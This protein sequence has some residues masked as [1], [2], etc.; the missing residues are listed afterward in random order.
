VYPTYAR[1]EDHNCAP[2]AV[3]PIG[4]VGIRNTNANA[5][6]IGTYDH[7]SV[8]VFLSWTTY[9]SAISLSSRRN[10]TREIT[11][12]RCRMLGSCPSWRASL[13][14]LSAPLPRQSNT[15][16][17]KVCDGSQ[18]SRLSM[19]CSEFMEAHSPNLILFSAFSL[20]H[21]TSLSTLPLSYTS[22]LTLL[23]GCPKSNGR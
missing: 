17:S 10:M 8:G 5:R 6:S 19:H 16:G 14:Q 21:S 4:W 15:Q 2:R 12:L 3:C 13:L 23:S 20:V 7:E 22:S 9:I 18:N 1:W 11:S